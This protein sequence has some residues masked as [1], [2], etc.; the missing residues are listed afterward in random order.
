[1]RSPEHGNP[2]GW[3]TFEVACFLALPALPAD[4]ATAN[5]AP[6]R[7]VLD[8]E[9]AVAELRLADKTFASSQRMGLFVRECPAGAWLPVALAAGE[10][11]PTALVAESLEL[12]AKLERGTGCVV[13]SG[14]V[15]D[16]RRGDDRAVDVAL[17]LPF[18]SA[19][20][21]GG[22]SDRV[23]PGQPPRPAPKRRSPD[24]IVE[25]AAALEP[26][27]NGGLAQNFLPIGCV[28]SED[29]QSGLAVALPPDT[30][31]RFR[32]AL[33]RD[34]GCLELQWQFGLSSIA[35]GEWKSRA[36]FRCEVFSVDGHWAM[37]DAWRRYWL[38]HPE[39]F[40]RRT[41][42]SGLWLVS[43]PSL[44]QVPDPQN[45]A[46]WQTTRPQDTEKGVRLG[47]E[48]YPYTITG[49]REVGFLTQ[50][51]RGYADVERILAAKPETSKRSRYTWEEVKTLVETSGLH[52][53][54]GR[55]LFRLRTTDWAGSSVSFPTNPSPFLPSS[56][57]RPFVAEHTFAEVERDGKAHPQL[58]GSFI[59]SLAMWG[60]YENYRRD[61]FAAVRSPLTHDHLGRVCLAN[62]M[63]HVDYLRELRRR[64]AP[65]LVFGNGPKPGRAFC[66]FQ[67]DV[68][69]VEF[70]PRDLEDRMQMDFVRC[71]AG[72]KPVCGLF[73]Y[74]P[75][76][77]L[78]R[79]QMED[80]VQRCTALGFTPETRHWKWPEY[81]DRD[82][83]LMS[84]FLPLCRRLHHAAW[85][86][87]TGAEVTPAHLWI[88]RFGTA[89]PELYF[90]VFNPGTEPAT[91]VLAAGD[92]GATS[93]LELVTGQEVSHPGQAGMLV[94]P[95]SV[96]VLQ[97]R[98]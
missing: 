3:L 93:W 10:E 62:W 25:G 88:E 92:A 1:M 24:Q 94:P 49:Q 22:I 72:P 8:G 77:G 53:P 57:E 6:P 7:I 5:D 63:P 32:F 78:P 65:R 50:P 20:W 31:C 14:A 64:I 27:E 41:Q 38:M 91:A 42:A 56:P 44:E 54:D 80:Y 9:G 74:E 58:A 17:R 51:L 60:S 69:G 35:S 16:V 15:E 11:A 52:G 26:L 76:K 2:G 39:S 40:A 85:Q 79:A 61:H 81:K 75:A 90:T 19:V 96:R 67:L 33:L 4:G 89:A 86:P 48:V 36:P 59:D 87:V 34:P 83:G 28:T 55:W 73:D 29:E 46:F 47:M 45:Y 18:A 37:R 98:P 97:A 95:K 13:I 23:A 70:T 71:V 43:A 84:R 82:A 68:F 12:R 30:P 21:W 66:A